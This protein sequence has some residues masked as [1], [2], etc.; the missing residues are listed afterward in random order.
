LTERK[1]KLKKIIFKTCSRCGEKKPGFEFGR[2][3][4]VKMAGE[5]F[6]ENVRT[7]SS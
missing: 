7:G 5:V 4:R 2:D 1:Q 6:A 3:K